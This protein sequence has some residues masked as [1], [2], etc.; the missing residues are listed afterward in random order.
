MKDIILLATS[1]NFHPVSI[2]MQ[3]INLE[4]G[5]SKAFSSVKVL[6]H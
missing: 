2:V 4:V 3:L 6:I 1:R 5:R